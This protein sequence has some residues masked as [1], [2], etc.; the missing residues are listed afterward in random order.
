VKDTYAEGSTDENGTLVVK[1]IIA[2]DNNISWLSYKDLLYT[3]TGIP[4]SVENVEAATE[5]KSISIFN[6]SGQKLN[7]L[8]KGI[9]IVDGKKIYVK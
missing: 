1:Y 6:L 8:Q 2:E 5:G 4:T 7:T 3:D 9:N